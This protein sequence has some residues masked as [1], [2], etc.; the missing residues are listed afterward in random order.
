MTVAK[1]SHDE[2][3]R[4]FAVM[5]A[6]NAHAGA[7]GHVCDSRDILLVAADFVKFMEE[8]VIPE[9]TPVPE[10]VPEDDDTVVAPDDHTM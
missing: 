3:H 1:W 8:G 2:E 7:I 6:V 5:Q 9:P 10:P 4:A